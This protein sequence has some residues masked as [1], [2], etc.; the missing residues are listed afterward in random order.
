ML[1]PI[2]RWLAESAL[3]KGDHL[4]GTLISLGRFVNVDAG[5]QV[6]DGVSSPPQSVEGLEWIGPWQATELGVDGFA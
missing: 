6:Y 2:R 3:C 4:C 5:V 1:S